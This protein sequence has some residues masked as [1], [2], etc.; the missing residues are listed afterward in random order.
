MGQELQ[1]LFLKS[2]SSFYRAKN[3]T[4]LKKVSDLKNSALYKALRSGVLK[5][6]PTLFPKSSLL[7][8]FD[9]SL[10]PL[11]GVWKKLGLGLSEREASFFAST[12]GP[13]FL[14]LM[15]TVSILEKTS[16]VVYGTTRASTKKNQALVEGPLA[17]LKGNS[18]QGTSPSE[19]GDL[20]LNYIVEDGFM[21]L[22]PSVDLR[23]MVLTLVVFNPSVY[24]V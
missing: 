24:F 15:K 10:T 2:R 3:L 19:G 8:P 14:T 22:W 16:I 18:N 12:G 13:S 5:K 20:I 1:G 9:N 21:E 7:V 11:L 6:K 4:T 23:P 17:L